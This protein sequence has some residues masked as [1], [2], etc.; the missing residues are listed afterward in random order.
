LTEADRQIL[1]TA[2]LSVEQLPTRPI[3]EN[4]IS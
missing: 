2:A 3:P 1:E 4:L